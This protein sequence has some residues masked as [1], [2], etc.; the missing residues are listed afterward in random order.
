[1]RSGA[2]PPAPPP[3]PPLAGSL[4]ASAALRCRNTSCV[5]AA[6]VTPLMENTP[7]FGAHAMAHD[8]GSSSSRSDSSGGCGNTASC[9]TSR[10]DGI[11]T[12][13]GA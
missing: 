10:V 4:A 11:T 7:G 12:T 8:R 2:A 1:M 6:N 9:V 13:D 5:H 3:A